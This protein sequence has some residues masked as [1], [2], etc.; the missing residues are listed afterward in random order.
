MSTD[1]DA[2]AVFQVIENLRELKKVLKE[3]A[4]VIILESWKDMKTAAEFLKQ[5]SS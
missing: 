2:S 4:Q 3:N 5:M 1:D